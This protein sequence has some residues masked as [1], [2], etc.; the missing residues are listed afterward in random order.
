[1][2]TKLKKWPWLGTLASTHRGLHTRG[3]LCYLQLP[4]YT[5]APICVLP[6]AAPLRQNPGAVHAP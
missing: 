1:M 3:E 4:R 2:S 6:P 5:I